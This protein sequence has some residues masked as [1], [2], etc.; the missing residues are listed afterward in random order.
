MNENNGLWP[1]DLAERFYT[2]G[3]SNLIPASESAW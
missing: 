1:Q 2:V 3:C